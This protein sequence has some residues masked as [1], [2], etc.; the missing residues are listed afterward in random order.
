MTPPL[1]LIAAA[2][3]VPSGYYRPLVAAFA[4]QGWEARALPN[5][6]F[7]RGEPTASRA[8]DW[9][10]AD[11]IQS[12]ADAVG[13]ARADDSN[14]PVI[15]LGH[16][17]GS[18]LGAGHQLHHP[19]AD[20]FVTVGASV[21]HFRTYPYGGLGVLLLGVTVPLA[22]RVRGFLPKPFFGAPGARTLMREWARFVRTGKP[23]FD[24]PHRITSPTLVVQLQ[25]DTYAVSASNKVFTAM[26]VE[27][28]AVTR[29]VYTKDAARA[30][31]GTSHH[32]QWVKTPRPVVDRIIDWWTTTHSIR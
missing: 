32:V 8:H 6:G 20:G 17:L 9:S 25:G 21:P 29:W 26:M 31:G 7:E 5:R 13:K 10:Y 2:M 24:V 18:Q 15:V 23:P 1:V 3:A 19:P 14:R 30:A 27:P 12:I 22:T 4:E 16:S 11:E 28:D